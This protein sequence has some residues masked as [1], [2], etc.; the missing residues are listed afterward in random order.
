LAQLSRK[1]TRKYL[2]QK[3][4]SDTYNQNDSK[5]FGES[6]LIDGFKWN[7]DENYLAEMEKLIK[8]KEAYLIEV[9]KKFAPKFDPENMSLTYV[10]PIFIW[11]TE[12][13]FLTEE[14]PAKVSINEAVEI[15]KAFW[16]DSAK[17]IVNW[18]LNK[19]FENY[20]EV[21]KD[22]ASRNLENNFSFFQKNS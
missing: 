18:V 12:M 5:L 21:K 17:K 13:L 9:I 8:E 7:I 11:A 19:L 2:F 3:L 4:F 16:E 20:E 1:K 15:S 10:L 6:F 22:F 14:I